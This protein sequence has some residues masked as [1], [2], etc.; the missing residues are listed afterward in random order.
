MWQTHKIKVDV[1]TVYIVSVKA[2][3]VLFIRKKLAIRQLND[4]N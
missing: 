4:F 2:K 1:S 3:K